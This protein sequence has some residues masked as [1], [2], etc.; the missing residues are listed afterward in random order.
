MRRSTARS[1]GLMISAAA[2]LHGL[3]PGS[4]SAQTLTWDGSIG[5]WDTD[6]RW[7]PGGTE[8]TASDN[9]LINDGTVTLDMAGEVA[10]TVS[11]GEFG[12]GAAAILNIESAG[13]LSS[14][15][16]S[17]GELAMFTG[18]VTVNGAGSSW[19]SAGDMLVGEYGTGT[20]NVEAGA[21]VSNLFGVLGDRTGSNGTATV[22]GLGSTWT[23]TSSLFIGPRGTGTLNIEAGGVVSNQNGNI[24]NMTGSSGSVTV[25]GSGSTWN[26][27]AD[28][29]VGNDGT[30]ALTIGAG[31]TVTVGG[32]LSI[33]AS[34][35]VSMAGGTL[36]F[37]SIS[38]VDLGKIQGT[39]GSL[40]STYAPLTGF[41][42]AAGLTPGPVLNPMLD[43]SGLIQENQGLLYGSGVVFLPLT[44]SASGEVQTRSGEL[45]FFTANSNTNAGEI[46]NF[47]GQIRFEQDMTNQAGGMIQG[48][49][50]FIANGGWTNDGVMAFSGGFADVLGDISNTAS[51]QIVVGGTGVATFYDDVVMDAG[52]LDINVS[53]GST[54]VFFGSFNGGN[55]GAGAVNILGDLRPGNSPASVSFGGDLSLGSQATTTIELAGT[56]L[57]TD[58]DQVVVTDLFALDGVLE[59]LL[60][61]GYAPSAGDSF[62]ILDFGSLTGTFDAVNLP[63]LGGNLQWDTADL[64]VD[65]TIS[66]YVSNPADLDGDGD[67]DGVDLSEF[68][69]AFTGPGGGP[70]SNPQADLDGDD[71]VDGVDLSLAFAAFTGPLSPGS[72]PEP[73]SL[74]ILSLGGLCLP[75]RRRD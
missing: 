46:N 40:V 47:G 13:T 71:D 22:T 74:L 67:I 28:L 54:A 43:H 73:G 41:T 15:K 53:A 20:L 66:V 16:G 72:V 34:G 6:V 48:R 61:D 18:I 39:S 3:Q 35:T 58:Y 23:S 75:R 14:G 2:L 60:I 44:N 62:D 59:V 26:N 69:T 21:V 50:E 30:G 70:P 8:P 10:N 52:N 5:N 65:G 29:A 32:T 33:G 17:I 27:A 1:A 19:T 36:A 42:D 56:T 51:G 11:V 9:A 38:T 24:G 64:Y 63:T 57:G 25:T 55:S 31:G 4:V 49:G 37:G 7:L 45:L 12:V 68:F